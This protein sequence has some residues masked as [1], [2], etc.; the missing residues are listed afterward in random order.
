[1]YTSLKCQGKTLLDYQY[2]LLKKNERRVKQIFSSLGTNGMGEH[3]ERV[4]EGEYGRCILYLYMKVE[5]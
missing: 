3:K 5:E 1:M 2:T 4:N